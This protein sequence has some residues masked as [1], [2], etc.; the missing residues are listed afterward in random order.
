MTFDLNDVDALC[1]ALTFTLW[2]DIRELRPRLVEKI[3]EMAD[4]CALPQLR[5]CVDWSWL[6]LRP[7]P[8]GIR[9]Y[10]Q[11]KAALL[12]AIERIEAATAATAELPRLGSP[13]R[14][15]HATPHRLRPLL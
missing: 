9:A 15:R 11:E 14:C 10:R 13:T 6:L 12:A 8:R 5:K 7:T 3:G 2:N 4:R 1:E